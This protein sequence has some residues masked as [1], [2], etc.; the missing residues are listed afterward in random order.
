MGKFIDS[1]EDATMFS[2]LGQN[3]GYCQVEVKEAY[4]VEMNFVSIHGFFNHNIVLW[5]MK[6]FRHGPTSHGL[7][8]IVQ[9]EAELPFLIEWCRRRSRRTCKADQPR[10]VFIDSYK[11]HWRSFKNQNRCCLYKFRG[12]SGT[13]LSS[14]TP[15]TSLLYTWRCARLVATIKNHGVEIFFWS[16]NWSR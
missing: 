1:S 9:Q 8:L 6:C 12:L 4:R 11:I 16:S 7:H 14:K 5:P 13:I 15:A 3:R 10:S 2:T